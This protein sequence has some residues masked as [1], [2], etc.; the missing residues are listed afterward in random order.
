[1]YERINRF[2]KNPSKIKF[3]HE[4]LTPFPKE[5]FKMRFLTDICFEYC[6]ITAETLEPLSKI[7]TIERIKIINCSMICTLPESLFKLP[8][9]KI[10]I[11]NCK[12][13]SSIPNAILHLEDLKVLEIYQ[14]NLRSI[15]EKVFSLPSLLKLDILD[16]PISLKGIELSTDV[17]IGLLRSMI[18]GKRYV[19]IQGLELLAKRAMLVADG[20]YWP[21]LLKNLKAHLQ[22]SYFWVRG[23]LAKLV[24]QYYSD[25]ELEFIM[26]YIDTQ[27]S[28][29]SLYPIYDISDLKPQIR[30]KL[31]EK[32]SKLS[33]F[34]AEDIEFLLDLYRLTGQ[35]IYDRD[36]FCFI[37]YEFFFE[38]HDYPQVHGLL[39]TGDEDGRINCLKLKNR[40]IEKLPESIGNLLNLKYL[41]LSGNELKELPQSI[42]KLSFIGINLR[43][44][45]LTSFPEFLNQEELL[46]L[47]VAHNYD[48][49][50][51]P[52]QFLEKKMKKYLQIGTDK[53][54]ALILSF[55]ESIL[56]IFLY[57]S[58]HP[59]SS[60]KTNYYTINE[61][62]RV[63]SLVIHNTECYNLTSI[64]SQ[65]FD[66]LELEV[67]EI[68][69]CNNLR[70]VPKALEQLKKLRT[71]RFIGNNLQIFPK[72]LIKIEGLSD[73]NLTRNNIQEIP[74]I[75]NNFENLE[76]LSLAFNNIKKFPKEGFGCKTLHTLDISGNEIEVLPLW[77]RDLKILKYLNLSANNIHEFPVILTELKQ[78]EHISLEK[79]YLEELPKELPESLLNKISF[80]IKYPEPE[81]DY[82]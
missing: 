80:S 70:T 22:N 51:I 30:E 36:A 7:K 60:G 55:I 5:L 67:L 81:E 63:S 48:I 75:I 21:D 77:F 38:P 53:K 43:Y 32:V 71:V 16:N 14:C 44:N 2:G 69:N 45:N 17:R 82:Y 73:I 26:N 23:M 35:M 1:M 34:V 62:G 76:S 9:K 52:P 46:F 65:I 8:L 4:T 79:N 24:V 64:P 39:L 50:F 33:Y 54:D 40:R 37:P 18:S 31:V 29:D 27:E 58:S 57:C 59:A 15:P 12:N 3:S 25:K 28:F 47:D 68:S 6:W 11:K 49:P 10:V 41:D 78:I 74:S 19:S 56:G 20:S 72:S 66:L 61:N 42:S 13:F